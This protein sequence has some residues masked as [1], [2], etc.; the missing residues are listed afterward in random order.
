MSVH[1]DVVLAPITAADRAEVAR[2]LH[3]ELNDRV[4]AAD[5]ESAMTVP[6]SVDAPNHGYLLRTAE[7]GVVGVYLAFYSQRI[8]EGEPVAVC[9]LGAWCVGGEFRE[10]S[11]RLLRAM[12][13]QKQYQFTDLSPSGS[14]IPLNARLKFHTLDTRTALVPNVP[15]LLSRA[16][17]VV[18]D[19]GEIA[20]ILRGAE[21][22]VFRDHEGA[23]AAR[24]VV[25]KRGAEHCYVVFRKDRRK[26]LPLFASILYVSNPEL[27][28]VAH[29]HVFRHLLLRHGAIA[30]LAERRVV[31]GAPR[32]SI[33][34]KHPR[35]K[36]FK[37]DKLSP[38]NVDYLY[39]ELTCVA[40]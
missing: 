28:R 19:R 37:G 20:R 17:R 25:L 35:T 40:W 21:L 18:S 27:F 10:H 13:A 23:A 9:N 32:P 33:A 38:E 36:M 26:N 2:F 31:G 12:L 1:Q 14:V 29:R 6:W 8:I 3:A 34:L 4:S 22:Q 11:L 5:W 15:W 39:S 16:V 30:T 24:H 7:Q